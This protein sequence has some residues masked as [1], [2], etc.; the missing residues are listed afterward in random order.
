MQQQQSKT[1]SASIPSLL[2]WGALVED[3]LSLQRAHHRAITSSPS[4]G[5]GIWV[6]GWV[7]GSLEDSSLWAESET[8]NG[9]AS[10]DRCA[11][12]PRLPLPPEGY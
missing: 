3:P 5:S 2:C 8:A 1:H 4:A 11:Q 9:L 7:P 10:P 6:L 12:G